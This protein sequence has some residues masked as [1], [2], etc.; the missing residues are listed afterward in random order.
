MVVGE[1]GV[2]ASEHVLLIFGEKGEM[3]SRDMTSNV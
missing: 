1:V 2:P 3:V